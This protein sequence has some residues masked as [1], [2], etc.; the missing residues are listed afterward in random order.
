MNSSNSDELNG[1]RANVPGWRV[2]AP[3]ELLHHVRNL[4]HSLLPLA[5]L[6]DWSAIQ[7]RVEQSFNEEVRL[8]PEFARDLFAFT[9]GW[10]AKLAEARGDRSNAI[11]CHKLRLLMRYPLDPWRSLNYL[12]L[13]ELL[14]QA[15]E[16]HEALLLAEKGGRF[17]LR[18]GHSQVA[19]RLA[20]AASRVRDA[21]P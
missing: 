19:A 12:V 4:D 10:L 18:L 11:T 2:S 1:L 20:S 13:V 8:F 14:E 21:I 16:L 9:V 15:G 5:R 3:V 17:A 7:E 6:R